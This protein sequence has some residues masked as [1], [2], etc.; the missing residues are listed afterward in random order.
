VLEKILQFRQ[1]NDENNNANENNNNNRDSSQFG[2]INYIDLFLTSKLSQ[3]QQ[4]LIHNP[5]TTTPTSPTPQTPQT[6]EITIKTSFNNEN[7]DTKLLSTQTIKSIL[8]RA[9]EISETLIDERL[10][11][12]LAHGFDSDDEEL[13]KENDEKMN[14]KKNNTDKQGDD[15]DIDRDDDDS[16]DLFNL[17][18]DDFD[19][20]DLGLTDDSDVEVVLSKKNKKFK[21]NDTKKHKNAFDSDEEN[22][23][24]YKKNDKNHK[25]DKSDKN[26]KKDGQIEVFPHFSQVP[27]PLLYEHSPRNPS[28]YNEIVHSLPPVSTQ[29]TS[30]LPLPKFTIPHSE[31]LYNSIHAQIIASQDEIIGTKQNIAQLKSQNQNILTQFEQSIKSTVVLLPGESL[32]LPASYFHEV[33]S[34]NIPNYQHHDDADKSDQKNN[35]DKEFGGHMALNY[36]FFPP[37]VLPKPSNKKQLSKVKSITQPPPQTTHNL[38]TFENPYQNSLFWQFWFAQYYSHKHNLK[39]QSSIEQ[40]QE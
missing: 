2:N 4:L 39:F 33:R 25:N 35:N 21:T 22:K 37:S 30:S 8:A 19:D 26:H 34:F 28:T 9:G 20:M 3:Q 14:E 18:R 12:S 31:S 17:D 23:T 32:F 13:M 6:P 24:N 16:D 5:T 1:N 15:I 36:W 29:P 38:P 10:D 11:L 40:K 7:I 27:L